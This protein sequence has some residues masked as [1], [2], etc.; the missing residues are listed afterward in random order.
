M[1]PRG[2]ACRN[3]SGIGEIRLQPA[4]DVLQCG[5]QVVGLAVSL[6]LRVQRPAGAVR[7]DGACVYCAL[8]IRSMRSAHNAPSDATA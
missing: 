2:V 3:V 4:D 1:E 7:D 6:R 8:S 5:C